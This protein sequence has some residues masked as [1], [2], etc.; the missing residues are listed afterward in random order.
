MQ[1]QLQPSTAAMSHSD[2]DMNAISARGRG[3]TVSERIAAWQAKTLAQAA[4][5]EQGAGM[6]ANGSADGSVVALLGIESVGAGRGTVVPYGAD[7]SVAPIT[8]GGSES[9]GSIVHDEASSDV[10]NSTEA[11]G[12]SDSV[13]WTDGAE[14]AIAAVADF[15]TDQASHRS[16]AGS[17]PRE[18]RVRKA[19]A[20]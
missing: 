20:F 4:L 14:S 17:V 18:G 2:L 3:T 9:V 6:S 19:A 5:A 16:G 7:T 11:T 8:R 15:R 13:Q 12:Q 1:S 10:G